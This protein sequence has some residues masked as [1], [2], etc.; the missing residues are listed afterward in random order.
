MGSNFIPIRL[1]LAEVCAAALM[2]AADDIEEAHAAAA[3]MDALDSNHRLWLA[4]RELG[5]I[6]GWILPPRRDADFAIQRS[7]R[8]GR[9]VTDAE[10]AALVAI[11]R[12]MADHLTANG[13]VT[14]VRTRVRLAYREGG[15]GVGFV[16][17]LLSQ[18]HKM[19]R[20]RALVAPAAD[21]R[22]SRVAVLSAFV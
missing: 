7:S 5:V 3:F 19:D 9:G 1:S 4:V 12:R 16:P 18:M 15:G 2:E 10:V 20:V 11:N 6:D 22:A 8:L 14:R 21:R 17:W 13:D